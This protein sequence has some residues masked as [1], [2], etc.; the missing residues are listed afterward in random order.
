[1]AL[2]W[3]KFFGTNICCGPWYL[4]VAS[5]SKTGDWRCSSWFREGCHS[6]AIRGQNTNIWSCPVSHLLCNLSY[7][8]LWS[9]IC[10]S[11]YLDASFS[12]KI[13][14]IYLSYPWFYLD[15][16]SSF[17]VSTSDTDRGISKGRLGHL[18]GRNGRENG[19]SHLGPSPNGFG[20]SAYVWK[21][22]WGFSWISLF[23][24][25]NCF[26]LYMWLLLVCVL[27]LLYMWL[28]LFTIHVIISNLYILVSFA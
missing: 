24:I 5:L 15:V 2:C 6:S 9:F 19:G 21:R 28:L 10:F 8:L 27:V 16:E 13:W 4:T 14:F 18:R 23:C 3:H 26:L 7:Y 20:G 17:N 11:K 12:L 1:L 22:D 25:S